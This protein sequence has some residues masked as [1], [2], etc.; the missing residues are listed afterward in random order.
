MS[1]TG[2]M[3]HIGI[4]FDQNG[5]RKWSIFLLFLK[6]LH[7]ALRFISNGYY[8][9]S[10]FAFRTSIYPGNKKGLPNGSPD[11]H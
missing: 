9:W 11:K 8:K 7:N 5:D 1:K 6:M 2:I 10:I 4:H 3:L